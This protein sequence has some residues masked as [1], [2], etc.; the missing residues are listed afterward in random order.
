MI[1]VSPDTVEA[2]AAFKQKNSLPFT[3]LADADRAIAEQF[4]VYAVRTRPNGEQSWGVQRV[5][6]IIEPDGTISRTFQQV[7]PAAHAKELL[8]ALSA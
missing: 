1:G 6:F 8:E 5:T 2:Q 4:G 3:L 7:D